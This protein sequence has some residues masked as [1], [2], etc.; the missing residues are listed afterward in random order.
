MMRP[1]TGGD[2]APRKPAMERIAS[3]WLSAD[4]LVLHRMASFHRERVGA[5]VA[6]DA[7]FPLEDGSK[8][9]VHLLP[10]VSERSRVRFTA[11][12]LKAHGGSVLPLG[13]QSGQHR[14]NAE[15]YA[16]YS[17]NGTVGAY[18][19]LLRDGRLEA[20]MAD[21]TYEQQ[22]A[23]LLRDGLCE[24]AIIDLVGQY[25]SFCRGIG[26]AAPVWVFAALTDS[27]GVRM[28]TW[29]GFG[30]EAI[31]R[32]LVFLPDI[33]VESLDID[34]ATYLRPLFDCLANAVGLERSLNYDEQG[35]RSERRGW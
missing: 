2:L 35:N 34:P 8:L 14:F 5:I 28:R 29:H 17:G 13:D 22:G 27:R 25:L 33:Q 11:S 15:G 23:R 10:E 9:I 26:L 31:H 4:E 3:G 21:A 1:Q 19:Q 7:S 32:D 6:G 12:D 16:S 18:S 20:V 24:R 30:G